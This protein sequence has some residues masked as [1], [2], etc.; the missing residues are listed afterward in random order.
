MIYP[1]FIKKNDLI[2]IT[3]PSDGISG[4]LEINRLNNAITKLKNYGFQI[5][6]TDNVRT[7]F[8][9]RSAD[10]KI[11]ANEFMSLI[12]DSNVKHI[13]CATGGDYLCEILPYIDENKI[14]NNPKWIQ[15]YSDIGTLTYLITTKL[16]IATSYSYTIKPYG[17]EPWDKSLNNSLELLEEKR[18]TVKSSNLYENKY[19]K[20]ETGLESFNLDTKNEWITL[21]KSESKG[22]IIGGCLESILN[23]FKEGYDYTGKFIN[24]YISDGFI[25]YFDV[26]EGNNESLIYDLNIFKEKGYFENIKALILGK[27][28]IG[29]DYSQETFKNSLLKLF[30]NEDIMIVLEADI[31]HK[32]PLMTVINGSIAEVKVKDGKGTIKYSFE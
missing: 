20:Y 17:M 4:E 21:N 30:E 22:R 26:F 1:D 16:D 27:R 2:G 23:L 11:R 7:S 10:G 31:S 3:A 8:E 29:E 13:I 14:K 24:K 9:G 6:E 18:N 25:W 15:G 28:F 19:K 12:T 32:G 5:K